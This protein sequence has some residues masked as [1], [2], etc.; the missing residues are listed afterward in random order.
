MLDMYINYYSKLLLNDTEFSVINLLIVSHS[1]SGLHAEHRIYNKRPRQI[2]RLL[3]ETLG[4]APIWSEHENC[5]QFP[6]K[7]VAATSVT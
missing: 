2:L 1:L 5:S 6:V 7:R 4:R 3:K